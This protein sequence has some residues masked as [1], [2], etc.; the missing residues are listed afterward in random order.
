MRSSAQA[1]SAPDSQG[2]PASREASGAAT[3]GYSMVGDN[4]G[5]GDAAAS[6]SS[7]PPQPAPFGGPWNTRPKLTGDWCGLREQF[8][9]CGVTFDISATTY[10]QGTASGGLQD[11]FRFGGRNDYLLNVDGEKAGLWKG[12]GL[13][14]HGE[15]VY[16]DSVNLLTGAVVPVNIGRSLPVVDGNVSALTG[17]KFSQALSENLILFAGKINTVDNVQQPFMPGRGLDAGFMNGAFLY[18]PVLG[19]TIPYST[20]GAGAAILVQAYPVVTLTVYDTN[21]HST[22]SVFNHLFDNGAVIYPTISLP[23]KF[24]GMTGHQTVWG[25]YSSGRYGVLSPEA[26]TIFPPPP[27]QGLPPLTLIRGSWWID[28]RFDQA[29]WVDPTDATRSW[30]VFGDFGLSDGK[31]NP[32]RWTAVLGVGGSS[33]ICS[34]KLDT[35]GIA[36]YY[37]GVSDSFKND[38][39]AFLP[40]RDER[41]V[42]LFYNVAVTPWF[43]VTT[44]LQVITPI[45][46]RAETSLV[47]GLRAKIDF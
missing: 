43:H 38:V 23:T 9:D 18:S 20:F 22:T 26:L 30:G 11:A 37:M 15:T 44:D 33:P 35:F 34:R 41:G 27:L 46:A 1:P 28:Y 29:L 40:V 13:N 10:Y 8:R 42:E 47:L 7:S 39:Q 2:G 3:L 6:S 4:S 5:D 36:Y 16:G 17:V 25:A 19:R 21:D 32:V 31:P 12:F 24:F 14:L 45:L